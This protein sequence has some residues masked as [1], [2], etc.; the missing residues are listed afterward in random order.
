MH[1]HKHNFVMS[2]AHIHIL[3]FLLQIFILYAVDFA[4]VQDADVIFAQNQA[5]TT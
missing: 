1:L 4:A 5:E 2:Y 3:G